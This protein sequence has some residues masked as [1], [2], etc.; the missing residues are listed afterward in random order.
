[1]SRTPDT[2]DNSESGVDGRKDYLEGGVY[3]SNYPRLA[4]VPVLGTSLAQGQPVEERSTA[5]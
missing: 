5:F 4:Q 1:M 2:S 3:G